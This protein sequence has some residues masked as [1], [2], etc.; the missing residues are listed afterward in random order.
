MK[1]SCLFS[2][3]END[4]LEPTIT[5]KTWTFDVGFMIFE[6]KELGSYKCLIW[7][8]HGKNIYEIELKD[9]GRYQ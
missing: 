2:Y 6:V 3:L 5:D 8:V 4:I 1:G 7:K 9:D